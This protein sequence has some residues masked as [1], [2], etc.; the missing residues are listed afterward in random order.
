MNPLRTL[1]G[2]NR[3]VARRAFG[4]RSVVQKCRSGVSI[5]SVVQNL[6]SRKCRLQTCRSEVSIRSVHQKCRSEVSIRSVD[7]KCPP[8]VLLRSVDQMC[9]S[10]VSIIEVWRESERER[11]R[12]R[13]DQKCPSEV[14][15]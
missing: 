9:C 5:S 12:E 11:E 15:V 1:G 7:Q 2:L 6:D 10:E 14:S 13:D 4:D 3:S 8:E